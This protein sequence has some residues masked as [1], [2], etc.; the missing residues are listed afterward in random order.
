MRSI[1]LKASPKINIDQEKP[2][3]A[4]YRMLWASFPLQGDNHDGPPGLGGT[5]QGRDH[6][7]QYVLGKKLGWI[8]VYERLPTPTR[9]PTRYTEEDVIAIGER[10]ADVAV[11]TRLK[12]KDVFSKRIDAG[13]TNLEEG[14]LK[15]WFWER[16][17]LVGDAA[18]KFTPNPG[19]GYMNGMEDVLALTNTLHA[20]LKPYRDNDEA[21]LATGGIEHA[22]TEPSTKVLSAAFQRYQDGR[23]AGAHHGCN[24]S[25]HE[26]R[27]L[28]QRTNLLWFFETWVMPCFPK[29]MDSLMLELAVKKNIRNGLVLDFVDGEESIKGRAAWVHPMPNQAARAMA[30]R[31]N[32]RNVAA[33]FLSLVGICGLGIAAS[34]AIMGR[35]KLPI[36]E[37]SST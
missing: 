7:L 16:I 2:F 37:T 29:W 25:G 12:V 6:S 10:W 31:K 4:D 17:A 20:I 1:A 8:F 35:Y 36:L 15:R 23:L 5:S 18:H 28:T 30:D 21:A 32:Q 22:G 13:M 14:V 26:I 11:G 19:Q 3:I 33:P 9:E 24:L 27:K 34:V